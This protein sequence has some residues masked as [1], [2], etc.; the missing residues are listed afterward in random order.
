MGYAYKIGN[1][2]ECILSLALSTNGLF[3][4]QAETTNTADMVFTDSIVNEMATVTS[5]PA[6]WYVLSHSIYVKA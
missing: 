6:D 3:G 4:E 2:A 1:A 5:N